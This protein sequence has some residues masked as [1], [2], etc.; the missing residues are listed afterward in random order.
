VVIGD[1]PEG[2][3]D[4]GTNKLEVLGFGC[5]FVLQPADQSGGSAQIF[6]QFVE[7]C[8]GDGVPGPNPATDKG[9]EII[10]LYKAY[11]DGSPSADS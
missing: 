2:G 6:G 4:G 1:C 3:T 9:P 8:E 10:Q 7:T 11:V 5:Y